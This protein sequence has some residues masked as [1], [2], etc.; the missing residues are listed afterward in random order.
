MMRQLGGEIGVQVDVYGP[1]ASMTGI[2]QLAIDHIK[3]F[4]ADGI[5]GGTAAVASH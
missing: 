4:D 2:C 3:Q 1:E 5:G